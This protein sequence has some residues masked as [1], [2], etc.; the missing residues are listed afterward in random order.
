MTEFQRLF[1]FYSCVYLVVKCSL[2][3]AFYVVTIILERQA[4]IKH[5]KCRKLISEQRVDEAQRW[6]V[7]YQ[8]YNKRYG[9]DLAELHTTG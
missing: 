4:R 7:A 5:A 3:I 9:S 8:L 2:A 1:L 6:K